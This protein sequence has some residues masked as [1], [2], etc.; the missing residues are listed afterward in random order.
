MHSLPLSDSDGVVSPITGNT[1]S[2]LLS[3][4]DF[5]RLMRIAPLVS[6]DLV[7]RDPD[8]YVLVG[9]R[10]NA[11]AQSTWFVPGG[12]IR[13]NEQLDAAFAR[14]LHAETG[15]AFPRAAAR[16]LGAYEHIYPDNSF[17]D[18]DYNTHYV[19]LGHELR[20]NERPEIR[21]DD[22]HSKICW[23]AVT[24]LLAHPDVHE[25]TKAYFRD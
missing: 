20:L 9:W 19:V 14:I 25:N 12:V 23:M 10:N 5:A 21:R 11:P 24:D 13:K 15:L 16:L 17:G 3:H 1:L 2:G 6:I 22:Q 4:Q 8:D 18:P 7:L